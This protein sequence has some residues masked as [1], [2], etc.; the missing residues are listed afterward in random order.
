MQNTFLGLSIIF[1]LAAVYLYV[2]SIL[3]G[4]TK[5]HL[6]TRF[7]LCVVALLTFASII[8]AGGNAGSIAIASIFLGQTLLI[9][10]LGIKHRDADWRITKFDATCLI[11]ALMG[12][13][14]WQISGNPIVGVA[15]AILA[16]AVAYLP[17]MIKTW[18]RPHTETQWFYSLGIVS[19]GLSLVAYPLTL[20]SAFQIYLLYADSIM[21]VCIYHVALKKRFEAL[22]RQ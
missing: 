12:I 6:V 3:R 15:F 20:A 13:V 19:T 16:D 7:V 9:F 1:G 5:P 2:A 8:A 4:Y 21:L 22:S 18:K 10:L 11:V 14:G 17:A